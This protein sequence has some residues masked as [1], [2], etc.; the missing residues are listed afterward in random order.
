MLKLV[1]LLNKAEQ[2]IALNLLLLHCGPVV[3]TCRNRL[4]TSLSSPLLRYLYCF[5]RVLGEGAKIVTS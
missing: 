1:T 5:S 2:H 4:P 3:F